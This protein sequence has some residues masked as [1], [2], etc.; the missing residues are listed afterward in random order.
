MANIGRFKTNKFKCMHFSLCVVL[1]CVNSSRLDHNLENPG[2]THLLSSYA[3]KKS[4]MSM[5]CYML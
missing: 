1:L 4:F 2:E 5:P 3:E